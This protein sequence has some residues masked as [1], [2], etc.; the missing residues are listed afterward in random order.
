MKFILLALVLVTIC[1]AQSD[2]DWIRFQSKYGKS[3]RLASEVATRRAIWESNLKQINQH[4]EEFAKGQQ[5]YTLG[6]NEFA[7]MTFEEF[8]K[9]YLGISATVLKDMEQNSNKHE[10]SGLKAAAVDLRDHGIVS[11]VKNQGS[12]GSCWSFAAV[13][14]VE[15]A[16]A[17]SNNISPPDL[18]EQQLVDCSK[19]VSGGKQSNFGCNGGWIDPSK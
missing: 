6:E 9:Q 11:E 4:N 14:T 17:R 10:M 16:W 8:S 2:N 1:C 3:Y 18:S 13:A 12:C 5:T 15:G 7:D 19:G